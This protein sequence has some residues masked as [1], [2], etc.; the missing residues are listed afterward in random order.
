CGRQPCRLG[1][2][3]DARTTGKSRRY[4]ER[5]ERRAAQESLY[6]H[7]VAFMIIWS[8]PSSP[9]RHRTGTSLT[10]C[11]GAGKPD[12]GRNA[13]V[14]GGHGASCYKSRSELVRGWGGRPGAPQRL[15]GPVRKCGVDGCGGSDDDEECGLHLQQGGLKRRRGIEKLHQEC[16]CDDHV[17]RCLQAGGHEM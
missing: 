9:K 11:R 10:D 8:V 6:R 5:N 1:G 14:T 3:F 13:P 16:R 7:W 4:G 15:Q 17:A 2:G 12:L